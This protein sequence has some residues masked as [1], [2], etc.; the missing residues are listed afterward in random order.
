MVDRDGRE[1]LPIWLYEKLVDV[2]LLT[3]RTCRGSG[4]LSWSRVLCLW[5]RASVLGQEHADL[6]P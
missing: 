1:D 6:A 2:L 5:L 4:G 3:A